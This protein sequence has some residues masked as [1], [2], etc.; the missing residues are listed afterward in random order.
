M[1]TPLV[2]YYTA[3]TLLR[4]HQEQFKKIQEILAGA[5]KPSED[6]LIRMANDVEARKRQIQNFI[7]DRMADVRNRMATMVA[8]AV[9]EPPRLALLTSALPHQ[10]F[11][12]QLDSVRA[13]LLQEA[14]RYQQAVQDWQAHARR[15]TEQRAYEGSD[16]SSLV[17]LATSLDSIQKAAH[18]LNA[19]R[20]TF[21]LRF[22]GFERA[23]GALD[24]AARIAAD[25]AN[26]G[27]GV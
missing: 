16:A 6:L 25:L 26:L 1:L 14:Q 27:A 18:S 8:P 4:Q 17:N 19:Q 23:E 24:T 7:T 12:L 21:E 22:G 9:I 3:D 13:T 10:F 20:Q 5:E 15:L 11:G 2:A